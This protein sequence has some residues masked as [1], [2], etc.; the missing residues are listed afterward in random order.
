MKRDFS[1]QFLESYS[2]LCSRDMDEPLHS[3]LVA[4]EE[5]SEAFLK[6]VLEAEIL[7]TADL[8]ADLTLLKVDCIDCVC[9]R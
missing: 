5:F 8:T 3:I 7:L 9:S 6:S 4:Y 1:L 2:A